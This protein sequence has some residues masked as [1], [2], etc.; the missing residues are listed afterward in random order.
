MNRRRDLSML[1]GAL[2]GFALFVLLA[3][4]VFAH[5]DWGSH[6]GSP[7]DYLFPEG[8]QI[9][10][11]RDSHGGFHGDGVA[12]LAAQIPPEDSQEFALS[13][14]ER[15]FTDGSI[16]EDIQYKLQIDPE[17]RI[18]AE[19][20]NSLWWFEDESPEDCFGEYTNYTFHA[21]DLDNAIYYY[22]E[23]DS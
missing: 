2:A 13:L 6:V 3:S 14:Q 7:V 1:Y 15:N 16:P 18:V 19:V 20:S 10:E 8:T 11:T 23:F 22:I 9:I 17:T 21:Y 5:I 4:W 12:F